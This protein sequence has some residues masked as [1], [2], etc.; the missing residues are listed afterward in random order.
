MC[1]CVCWVLLYVCASFFVRHACVFFIVFVRACVCVHAGVRVRG[2]QVAGR[3][4]DSKGGPGS[5][6]DRREVTPRAWCLP[7][8]FIMLH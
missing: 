6:G 2:I 5:V 4:A 7:N 3:Q 1:V 8:T